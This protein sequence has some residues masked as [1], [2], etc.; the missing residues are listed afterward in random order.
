MDDTDFFL[1]ET[2]TVP[3]IFRLFAISQLPLS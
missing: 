1:T 3:I 2:I